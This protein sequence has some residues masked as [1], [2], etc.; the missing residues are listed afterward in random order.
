MLLVPVFI[1][2]FIVATTTHSLAQ[3]VSPVAD[4]G[5]IQFNVNGTDGDPLP[6]RIHLKDSAGKSLFAFGQPKWNDHFVCSGRVAAAVAAGTYSWE[7]ERGPEWKRS[8]GK[9]A[10]AKGETAQVEVKLRRVVDLNREGWFSADMHIHRPVKDIQLLMLAEDLN[11][12][13]AI[14]WW[15]KPAPNAPAADQTEFRF[16][17]NRIYCTQ[18]GED[19]R[20]GGAL[21]YF[22]LAK[23]LDLTV[24]S[25]EFPSPMRFVT[26]AEQQNE[27]VWI[28]IEKP[29]WWDVP[30]W[31]ATGRMNSIGI[32]HNHMHRSGVLDGE[33]W[34]KPR[35]TER[36]A[37]AHGNGLW[38]QEIYYHV[39]NSGI[40]IP[41]SAGSASGV[42]PNPVGYNRVYAHLGDKDFTRDN[43]FSALKAG[44]CFVTNGP[45]LRVTA[46]RSLPGKV[47]SVNEPFQVH[48]QVKLTS[49]DPVSALELIVNGEVANRIELSRSDDAAI[50]FDFEVTEPGW[51]LVRAIADVPETFRFATTAPW[52]VEFTDKPNRISQASAQFFLDWVNERIE[53][54]NHNVPSESTRDAINSWHIQARE[55]WLDR[56]ERANAELAKTFVP[57]RLETVAQ[58]SQRLLRILGSIDGASDLIR[59]KARKANT[60]FKLES[61]LA[62]ATLLSVSVNPESRVKVNALRS[63]VVLQQGKS[64]RFLVRIENSAG[65]TAPLSLGGYDLAKAAPELADWCEIKVIDS[66][67]TSRFLSG[68][69]RGFKVIDITPHVSG[70]RELRIIGEAGQGTQDLGFRAT[71]DLLLNIKPK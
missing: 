14:S 60:Y 65:I 67:N 63:S 20:E 42:L 58:M 66:P 59:A 49:G 27:S 25:R 62:P 9:V 46:N 24:T 51:F 37:G 28:D 31:L 64:H 35:D 61:A 43:W 3:Q 12:A 2:A 33:A 52:Y 41:P 7:I 6:C 34:G 8:S 44:R 1:L 23:P 32:A 5:T 36:F 53:R 26:Q 47:L 30:T 16:A 19:E 29:F 15:N 48:F 17:E 21:L 18:I 68:A 38:T 10:V 55:F 54:V 70:V 56:V 39:L 4:L 45:L 71:T 50:D 22:G 57:S 69:E 11:L 13:P 40:R